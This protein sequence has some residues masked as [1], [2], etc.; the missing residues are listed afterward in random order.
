MTNIFDYL[1]S[2]FFTKQDVANTTFEDE[3]N[4]DLYMINRWGSMVDKDC[5]QIINQTTNRFGI[6]LET[7]NRQYNFL[8]AVAPQYKYKKINYIKRKAVE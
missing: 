1:R 6:Q 8:K 3:K 2:I 7:K 5:A 4:F